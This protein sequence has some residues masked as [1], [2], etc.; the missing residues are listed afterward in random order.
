MA[1]VAAVLHVPL[2]EMFLQASNDG[3]GAVH[4]VEENVVRVVWPHGLCKLLVQ[5][6]KVPRLPAL[7]VS[8][9]DGSSR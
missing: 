4:K 5:Q 9:S 3:V 7:Q 2:D 1:V 6:D 8:L